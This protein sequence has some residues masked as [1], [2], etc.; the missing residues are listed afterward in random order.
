[1]TISIHKGTYSLIGVV[2][3][4]VLGRVVTSAFD[5]PVLLPSTD[6][7]QPTVGT[8][9]YCLSSLELSLACPAGQSPLSVN[10][11][12]HPLCWGAL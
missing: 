7:I 12:K 2:G 4:L 5:V 9:L 3:L 6:F 1:M 10:S 11:L 8:V